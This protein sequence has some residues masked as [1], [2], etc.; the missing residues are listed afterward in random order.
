[1][2]VQDMAIVGVELLARCYG[3]RVIFFC[4][5]M[6]RYK[7]HVVTYLEIYCRVLTD[8]KNKLVYFVSL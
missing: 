8:L 5:L 6:K 4:N 1:M 7:V 3:L 2:S